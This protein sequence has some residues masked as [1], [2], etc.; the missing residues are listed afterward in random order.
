LEDD[1]EAEVGFVAFDFDAEKV[2]K[3]R[4]FSTQRKY[5]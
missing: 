1:A 4:V 2:K 5:T 3:G